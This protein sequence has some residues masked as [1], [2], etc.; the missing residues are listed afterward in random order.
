MHVGY[1]YGYRC[2]GRWLYVGQSINVARRHKGHLKG[3]SRFEQML[4]LLLYGCGIEAELVELERVEGESH[5]DLSFN[6]NWQETAWMFKLHTYRAAFGSVGL[7]ITVPGGKDHHG[8]GLEGSR[9]A[10]I[11][12]N[13]DGKSIV[14]VNSGRVSSQ[15]RKEHPEEASANSRK[16]GAAV[17]QWVKE[18]PEEAS[19]HGRKA[20]AAAAQW[21]KDHPDEASANGRKAGPIATHYRWHVQ[22]GIVSPLCRLCDVGVEA[23][24]NLYCECE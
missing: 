16:G 18:H 11:K 15:W 1:I 7:N 20:A 22:L 2:E 5:K 12:K 6:L 8:M 3:Q 21:F 9:V 4:Q 24:V 19:A 13:S 23:F 14:A 17:T 10:H